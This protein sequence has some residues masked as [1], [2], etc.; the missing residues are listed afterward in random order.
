MNYY[1]TTN[2]TGGELKSSIAKAKAQAVIILEFF[3]ANPGKLYTPPEVQALCGL[4]GAPL[5]SV[6]RAITCLTNSL[7]LINTYET[8]PGKYGAPNFKWKLNTCK[9]KVKYQ[10][11][12]ILNTT[13]ND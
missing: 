9:H 7:D 12:N 11:L 3:K 2:L 5:T 4:E 6:R 8:S 1:N 13:G 10:Q